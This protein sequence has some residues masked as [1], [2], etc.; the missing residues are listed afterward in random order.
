M[1]STQSTYIL[2]RVTLRNTDTGEMSNPHTGAF[3]HKKKKYIVLYMPSIATQTDR[4]RTRGRSGARRGPAIRYKTGSKAPGNFRKGNNNVIMLKTLSN[5]TENLS[6]SYKESF[7]FTNMGGKAGST[8]CL[9]R[10][11]M[12]DP[13]RGG[14]APM[15]ANGIIS[16]VGNIKTGS[17]DPVFTRHAYRDTYNLE[18]RL[19]TYAN[20]Y[21][22]CVVTSSEVIFNV[23]PKLNQVWNNSTNVSIVP[24]LINQETAPGSGVYELK[25]ST[26]PSASGDLYV[27]TVRQQSQ[28][29][30]HDSLNGTPPLETLKQGIPGVRMSKVNVTPTS[31]KGVKAKLKYTPKSQYDIKDWKDNKQFLRCLNGTKATPITPN[32]DIKDSFAYLGIGG[33]INGVDPDPDV[34]GLGIGLANCIVEV[35]VRYNLHFS[36]RFNIDGNNEPTPH[37]AE[38]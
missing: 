12:N 18:D 34:G 31:V 15:P 11:S 28:N 2:D 4:R 29:Q 5:K 1:L 3:R 7:D 13:F 17:T 30:L 14:V 23:R 32:V 20:E 16:V 6:I 27:W 33:R 10:V 38:L 19:T 26:G 35:A 9:I 8:P 21:R 36:E 37:H 22:S 25:T 24:Y